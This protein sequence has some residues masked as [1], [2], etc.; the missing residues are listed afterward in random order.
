[1]SR[2]PVQNVLGELAVVCA[3]LD[4][5]ERRVGLAAFRVPRSACVEP[6]RELESQHLP[7][8][9]AD[10][11]AGVEVPALPDHGSVAFVIAVLGLV[12]G[13]FH[14]ARTRHGTNARDFFAEDFLHLRRW[15]AVRLAIR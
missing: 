1:V 3:R 12:E 14:E 15:L 13:H 10:A 7:E 4:D 9:W 2:E 5:L 6:L 11:D 8:E